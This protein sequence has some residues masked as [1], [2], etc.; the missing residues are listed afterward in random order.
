MLRYAISATSAAASQSTPQDEVAL[1]IEA[2]ERFEEA[3]ETM[4]EVSRM[5]SQ[6]AALR[7]CH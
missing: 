3:P 4:R 1:K 2:M 7:A 6:T 5:N